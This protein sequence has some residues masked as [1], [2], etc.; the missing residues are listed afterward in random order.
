VLIET[1]D[2]HTVTEILNSEAFGALVY[3]VRQHCRVTGDQVADVFR[4]LDERHLDFVPD[5]DDP[6][7]YLAAKIRDLD[8]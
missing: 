8:S 6:A 4:A 2:E 7:A 3:R 5:A 1:F